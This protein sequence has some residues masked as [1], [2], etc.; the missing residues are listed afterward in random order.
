MHFS[1]G[2]LP[3]ERN[4]EEENSKFLR[5]VQNSKAQP[6][7]SGS[8]EAPELESTTPW[9]RIRDYGH[10]SAHRKIRSKTA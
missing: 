2:Y 3:T 1:G 10:V 9:P 4:D 6:L 5:P 7:Y 8:S